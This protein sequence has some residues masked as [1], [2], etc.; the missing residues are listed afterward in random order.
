MADT[1]FDEL[2]DALKD[3]KDFL[4]A[5][6]G[7]IKPAIDALKSI[8]PDQINDLL[9][10]LGELMTKLKTE[11]QNLD[12]S[13]IPGLGEAA[14]FTGKIGSF[15]EAAKKLLPAD[16]DDF[17]AVLDAADVVTGLPSIDDVKA[18]IIAL[19]DAIIGHLN[20]LKS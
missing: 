13:A 10:K 2:K 20:T 1:L 3:F 19:I 11:I 7:T 18:E 14:E 5:N 9:T 16:S 15:V 4:D 17:D 12:V 8:I 6:V